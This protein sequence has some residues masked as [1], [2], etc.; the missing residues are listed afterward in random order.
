MVNKTR[1]II[2]AVAAA[3]IAA[4]PAVAAEK[5]AGEA[6][7]KMTDAKGGEVGS[8]ML[9]QTPRGVL[10][11]LDLANLP[12][13]A[14]AFHIHTTGKCE[15]PE[16]TSAGGHFNP[17]GAH[18]G[19][20]SEKGEH[21]GDLPNIHVPDGGKLRAEYLANGVTLVDGKKMSL[22]DEDGSALVV[23]AKPDDYKSDPAGDAGG[24]IACGVV[25]R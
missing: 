15:P 4:T 22:F 13:G 19:F 25:T 2:P 6:M 14:H 21:A 16:F 17:T 8:I 9:S 23:H 5:G 18:H 10:L 3:M 11:S 1:C 12:P 20:E 7:A 24:R